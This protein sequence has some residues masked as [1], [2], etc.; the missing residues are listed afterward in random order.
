MDHISVALDHAQSLGAEYA[1]IRI[2]KTRRETIYLV[3]LSL[4]NTS[5]NVEHGY[6]IR[7]MKNGAWGFAHS[8]IFTNDEVKKTVE[9]AIKV[10]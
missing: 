8:N 5:M 10:D 9:S 7:V 1:D 4:K 2:Q 3:D 6:G